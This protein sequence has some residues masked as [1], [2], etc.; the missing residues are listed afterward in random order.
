MLPFF[1]RDSAARIT[2][3][4]AG[5]AANTPICLTVELRMKRASGADTPKARA[6]TNP[7]S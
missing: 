6:V 1:L 2:P 3:L 4:D 5:S 7:V